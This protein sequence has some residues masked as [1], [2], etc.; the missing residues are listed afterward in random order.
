MRNWLAI[1]CNNGGKMCG[2]YKKGNNEHCNTFRNLF[3]IRL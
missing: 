1:I 3:I 2:N